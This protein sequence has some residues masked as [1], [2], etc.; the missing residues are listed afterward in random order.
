MDKDNK[1]TISEQSNENDNI[2]E[3]AVTQ[4]DPVENFISSLLNN[5]TVKLLIKNISE[6]ERVIKELDNDNND[7]FWEFLKRIDLIQKIYNLFFVVVTSGIILMLYRYESISQDTSQ[8]LL[9]LIIGI[10]ITNAISTFFKATK[11]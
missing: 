6:N 7:N 5:D 8:T 2:E 1:D 9:T 10:G 3:V 4:V 11:K